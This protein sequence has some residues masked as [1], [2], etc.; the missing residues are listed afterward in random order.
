MQIHIHRGKGA[1]DRTVVMNKKLLEVLRAYYRK[2]KPVDYL[3]NGI[4]SGTPYSTSAG[5]WAV[6]RGRALAKITKKCSVHTLRHC[7]ATH[8]LELGTD[9]VFLQEQLGHKH[10]KTTAKYIRLCVERYRQI[11][12][13]LEKILIK[14]L[15]IIIL[16][17]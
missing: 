10:L 9:I 13:P 6:R 7:Y 8:H 4:K 17:K 11:N 15:I 5:Q 12:H 3:F 16:D 2:Y 14:Y 1:K